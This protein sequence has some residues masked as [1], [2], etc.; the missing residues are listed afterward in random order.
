[1]RRERE[2]EQGRNEKKEKKTEK[3]YQP[4]AKFKL[5]KKE[6]IFIQLLKNMRS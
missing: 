5:P 2:R 4:L 6:K 1:M 3:E